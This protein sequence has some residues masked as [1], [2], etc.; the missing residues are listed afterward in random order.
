MGRGAGGAGHELGRRAV[1][2]GVAGEGGYSTTTQAGTGCK[3]RSWCEDDPAPGPRLQARPLVK[4]G[5][6]GRT[7]RPS[8]RARNGAEARTCRALPRHSVVERPHIACSMKIFLEIPPVEDANSASSW[9]S[10]NAA[11][12]AR[13]YGSWD[14]GTKRQAPVPVWPILSRFNASLASA[15]TPVPQA[16]AATEED[17]NG[18]VMHMSTATGRPGRCRRRPPRWGSRWERGGSRAV[19]LAPPEWATA[20]AP[21]GAEELSARRGAT[22]AIAVVTINLDAAASYRTPAFIWSSPILGHLQISL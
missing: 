22:A 1:K 10:A 21:G 18:C 12:P 15:D 3:C 9:R 8:R 4:I 13:P 19:S 11:G 5:R 6:P 20:A 2:R 16:A 14:R 7:G 17:A